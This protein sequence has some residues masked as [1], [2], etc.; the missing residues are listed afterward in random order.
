MKH[1]GSINN[2][3]VC[4]FHQY[5]GF[6]TDYN[7]ISNNVRFENVDLTD[8]EIGELYDFR[9]KYMREISSITKNV[10]RRRRNEMPE[11][12]VVCDSKLNEGIFIII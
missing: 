5:K 11:V 9:V 2:S 7:L 6:N 12:L 10:M 3:T 1:N 8:L 4:E